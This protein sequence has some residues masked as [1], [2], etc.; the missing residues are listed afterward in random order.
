MREALQK[1]IEVA[2]ETRATS[3]KVGKDVY[4]LLRP[5]KF[6]VY[7]DSFNDLAA[8]ARRF[9]QELRGF[10]AQGVPFS[11]ALTRDGLL[12]WGIDPVAEPPRTGSQAESWRSWLTNRLAAALIQAKAVRLR[13]FAPWQFAMARLRLEGVDT[14]EWAPQPGFLTQS[15]DHHREV[16]FDADNRCAYSA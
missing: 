2:V 11:A 12:S 9:E 10:R 15:G 1:A 13:R 4:G 6:V 16:D 7:F 5:D 3:F 8:A 14:R